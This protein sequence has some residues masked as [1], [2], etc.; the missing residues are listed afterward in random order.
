MTQRIRP[1][2]C[3][4][5]PD[6]HIVVKGEDEMGK[7]IVIEGQLEAFKTL[8]TFYNVGTKATTSNHPLMDVQEATKW[9]GWRF[10][11]PILQ[12]PKLGDS[13]VIWGMLEPACTSPVQ[14]LHLADGRI[15]Q[16]THNAPETAA[17]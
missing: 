13:P 3:F 4:I 11:G 15:F 2:H 14:E 1:K 8:N 7:P 9:I 6:Y 12:H 17:P 5:K 16:L 10:V